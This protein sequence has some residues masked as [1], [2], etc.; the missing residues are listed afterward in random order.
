MLKRF[1][2]FSTLVLFAAQIAVASDRED[3]STRTR[4]VAQVFK[5]IMDMPDHGIPHQLL[6]SING[7]AILPGDVKFAFIN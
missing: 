1:L 3:D 2:T 5:E 6:E 4:R 7:I